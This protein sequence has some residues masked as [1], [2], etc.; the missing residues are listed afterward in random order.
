MRFTETKLNGAYIIDLE[1]RSDDRGFFAR[2]FCKDEFA[3]LG[4]STDLVQ[5]NLSFNKLA[6]TL[7]GMHFQTPPHQETKVVR[8][9]MGSVY[10]VIV[11][12]RQDSPTYLEWVGVELSAQNHKMIYIPRD[13]A[14]GYLTLEDASEVF[15]YVDAMYEPKSASGLRWDDPALGIKWPAQ[16]VSLSPADEKWELLKGRALFHG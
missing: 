14:H 9:T 12:I 16:P 3:N 4:L 6:G 7:R 1:L 10:D 13:F 11:D 5:C 15:Y 8:C 2:A